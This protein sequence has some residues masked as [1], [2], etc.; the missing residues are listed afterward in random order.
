MRGWNHCPARWRR[1]LLEACLVAVVG[2]GCGLVPRDGGGAPQRTMPPGDRYL[3]APTTNAAEGDV[4]EAT[5]LKDVREIVLE[6]DGDGQPR[7][8]RVRVL[9]EGRIEYTRTGHARFRT[10]DET[11][12]AV[13]EPGEFDALVQLL[14]AQRVATLAE[15]YH[16]PEIAGGAWGQLRVTLADGELQVWWRATHRPDAVLPIEEAI[17]ALGRRALGAAR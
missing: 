8:V 17:L 2:S 3:A 15:V 11:H 12:W 16:D 10:E 9:R 4:R 6:R 1:A 5:E 13:L 7:G 14:Q